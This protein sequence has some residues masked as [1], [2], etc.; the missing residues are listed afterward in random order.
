M[1]TT[2]VTL[3]AIVAGSVQQL[4]SPHQRPPHIQVLSG[5]RADGGS[6]DL[7]LAILRRRLAPQAFDSVAAIRQPRSREE[8]AWA[9]LVER[10]AKRWPRAA[11]SLRT[12]F[13]SVSV[14]TVRVVLGN[15]G[16]EDAFTHDSVTIGM[17]LG[18]LQR[19]YG[20]AT[21]PEN[22]DRVDRFFRHEFVHLLQKRWL[23]RHPV[24]VTSPLEAATLDAW[25]EGLGNYFSLG[26]TWWPSGGAASPLTTTTLGTLEP[27]FV[28]RLTA[29]ACADSITARPLLADLSSGPFA[30]KW[31]A[32]TVAL[33]LLADVQR[34]PGALHAF[35]IAG[36]DAVWK[37]AERHLPREL[38]DSLQPVRAGARACPR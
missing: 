31:G 21:I 34:D 12:L 38:A 10:H 27:V 28:S 29:L 14:A 11:E 17:D 3:F 2:A 9:R 35:A 5:S 6:T 23:S 33:W 8:Q 19:V 18:A 20:D 36:P 26:P 16:G 4:R 1:L 24:V 13:D 25:E 7:W 15:R 22:A 37:L 32:V 30:H